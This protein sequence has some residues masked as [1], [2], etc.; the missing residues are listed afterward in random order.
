MVTFGGVSCRIFSYSLLL[1]QHVPQWN[2]FLK[3]SSPPHRV[4]YLTTVAVETVLTLNAVT[5]LY[6]IQT[7]VRKEGRIS[8]R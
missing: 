5:F 4:E 3:R 1:W 2:G 8:G 6:N 7:G